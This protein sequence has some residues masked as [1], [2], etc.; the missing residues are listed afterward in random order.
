MNQFLAI[1]NEILAASFKGVRGYVKA[2]IK[3]SILMFIILC[4]GLWW[5][6]ISWW[7][8]KALGIAIIDI[9]PVLGS[10]IIMLPWA[11]VYL[12]MGQTSLAWQLG[13]LYIVLV[14]VRQIADPLITGR[15]IG[16]RPIY[17]LLSTIICIVLFGPIGAVLGAIIAVIIKAIFDIKKQYTS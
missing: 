16:V 14:I 9:I 10:G 13:L 6:G 11:L 4:I 7:G 5:I 8:V 3:M 15:E 2:A 12:L 17:T 1:L